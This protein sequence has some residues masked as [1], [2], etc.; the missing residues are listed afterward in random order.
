MIDTF[1]KF[2]IAIIDKFSN[3]NNSN[4]GYFWGVTNRKDKYD[5]E[6]HF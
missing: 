2:F 6:V 3:F 5:K 4:D 1:L